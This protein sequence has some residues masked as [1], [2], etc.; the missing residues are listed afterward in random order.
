MQLLGLGH[1]HKEGR[2]PNIINL[3]SLVS[4]C[5]SQYDQIAMLWTYKMKY[6]AQ[7]PKKSKITIGTG[8]DNRNHE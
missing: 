5:I 7:E 6:V 3:N 2:T 4:D 1:K 8:I